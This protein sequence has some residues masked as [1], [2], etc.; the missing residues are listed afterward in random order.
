MA[1]QHGTSQLQLCAAASNDGRA[2]ICAHPSLPAPDH[3]RASPRMDRVPALDHRGAKGEL[4]GG[5][6]LLL[7]DLDG[8][9]GTEAE[10]ALEA[11]EQVLGG[12]ALG[13]AGRGRRAGAVGLDDGAALLAGVG[14]GVA[15]GGGA[16]AALLRTLGG[17]VLALD[18]GAIG[19]GDF[20]G[21]FD[22]EGESAAHR[23]QR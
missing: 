22:L 4:T 14:D 10:T 17:D 3:R 6:G 20:A 21:A 1:D 15:V 23:S 13:G 9:G 2:A 19:H 5:D 11:V 12:G 18:L 8:L 7:A 16:V